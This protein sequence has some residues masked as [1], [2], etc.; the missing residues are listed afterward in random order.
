MTTLQFEFPFFPR[1]PTPKGGVTTVVQQKGNKL[2]KTRN[3]LVTSLIILNV[4]DDV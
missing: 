4:L 3:M 2:L 1:I